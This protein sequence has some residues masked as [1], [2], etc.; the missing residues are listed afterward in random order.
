MSTNPGGIR[1]GVGP[2]VG[3]GTLTQAAT[4]PMVFHRLTSS[5]A[6]AG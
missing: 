3:V 6:F 4:P 2:G 5:G 1:F